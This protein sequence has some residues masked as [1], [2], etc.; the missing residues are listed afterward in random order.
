MAG[1][2]ESQSRE[3]R[4]GG[5]EGRLAARESGTPGCFGEWGTL[6][7]AIMRLDFVRRSMPAPRIM[8]YSTQFKT[9]HRILQENGEQG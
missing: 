9:P 3:R 2:R 4:R 1:V 7:I 8:V 6:K 5:D